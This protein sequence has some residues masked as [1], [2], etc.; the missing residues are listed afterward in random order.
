VRTVYVTEP[1][2]TLARD[3]QTLQLRVKR[4]VRATMPVFEL[5]QLVLVGNIV[6]TPGAIDLLLGRGVDTVFVSR[7]GRY[8]GR[9]VA[10]DSW[11]NVGLRFAQYERLGDAAGALALARAV[12]Q[13]KIRN[14]RT[15][16][17]RHGRRH[18]RSPELE[19]ADIALRAA[20]AH[21]ELATT[22]DTVR[23]CEGA[24]AAAYF[25]AFGKL[26]RN[27]SLRFEG[28]TRR[29]PRDPVN[30]LL[31]FGYTLLSNVVEAAVHTVG[32][33]PYVG[34]LHAVS[35]GRPSLVCDLVEEFR[36]CVVDSLVLAMVNQSVL[37][38]E[39][40]V[41]EDETEGVTMKRDALRYFLELFE[42]RMD[43]MTAYAPQGRSLPWRQVIVEQVRRLARDFLGGETYEAFVTR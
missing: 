1:G 22:M 31:S 40:F 5:E 12:V 10:G 26:L 27:S 4:E 34:A 24:A 6:L 41:D 21:L 33:D 25:G 3:G 9:L 42:R 39:D 36:P 16:L 29:P 38:P 18:G 2:A 7:Y 28:R 11:R 17:L 23:G 30:A 19:R 8:R 20:L 43:K 32:L 14:Q 15:L 35:A 37:G 13:G